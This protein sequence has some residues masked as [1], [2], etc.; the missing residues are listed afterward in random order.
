MNTKHWLYPVPK[1][2]HT[3]TFGDAAEVVESQKSGQ[4]VKAEMRSGLI[5]S[6]ETDSLSYRLYNADICI[7][8]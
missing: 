7:D 3:M 6:T 8:L 2:Y 5:H 4:S 1:L